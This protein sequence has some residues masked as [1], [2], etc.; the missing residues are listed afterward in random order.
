MKIDASS[1]VL[2]PQ[3]R[4]VHKV[5]KSESGQD[6]LS[7]LQGQLEAVDGLQHEAD[8][9]SAGL[10]LGQTGIQESMIAVQKA[11]ISFRMLMQV[12]NK[13]LDAYR[14]IMRMQV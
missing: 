4:G 8:A 5:G 11:D 6:F 10:A 12:R 9:A 1:A 3:F 7:L 2:G 13:V 14:E